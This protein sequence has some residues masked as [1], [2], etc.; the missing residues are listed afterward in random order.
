MVP[1]CRSDGAI[2]RSDGIRQ[3]QSV[4]ISVVARLIADAAMEPM[5]YEALKKDV[6]AARS[7]GWLSSPIKDDPDM[8]QNTIP[9]PS[10]IR[11]KIYIPTL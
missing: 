2:C 6:R 4:V 9:N 11:A 10:S 3:L 8:T 7:F 1:I 5:K